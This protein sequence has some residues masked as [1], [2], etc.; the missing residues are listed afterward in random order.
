MNVKRS[1][2]IL[3]RNLLVGLFFL[4]LL[5]IL[6]NISEHYITVRMDL[7]HWQILV[8]DLLTLTIPFIFGLVVLILSIIRWNAESYTLEH[9]YVLHKFGVLNKQ[10]IDISIKGLETISLKQGFF[11]KLF[12][13]GSI[14]LITKRQKAIILMDLQNPEEITKFF[15]KHV[16]NRARTANKKLTFEEIMRMEEDEE[17]E[18][19]S[20]LR[21]DYKQN[22][23]NKDLEKTIMKTV[24]GFLNNSGGILVIGVDDEKKVL[25]LDADFKTLHKK[26]IDGFANQLTQIFSHYIGLEYMNLIKVKLHKFQEKDVCIVYASSSKV[27]IYLKENEQSEFYVR[28][29]NAT[30]LLNVKEAN[31]YINLHWS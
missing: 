31:T 13:F 24:T 27:P 20:S 4:I 11:G 5:I 14:N 7:T 9:D 28:T 30:N 10:K 2:F 21:W 18:F 22:K 15:K 1:P 19:K 29:G 26:N 12:D 23:V 17:I 3:I 16:S 8:I 25:G 6:L